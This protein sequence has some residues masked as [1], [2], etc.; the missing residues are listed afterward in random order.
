MKTKLDRFIGGFGSWE[1]AKVSYKI[2]ASSRRKVTLKPDRAP[3]SIKFMPALRSVILSGRNC[4]NRR[5][6]TSD[7]YSIW[8]LRESCRAS[9]VNY[10]QTFRLTKIH[11]N[12]NDV[13]CSDNWFVIS[14]DGRENEN[15]ASL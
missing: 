12:V 11:G 13:S 5:V 3:S 4:R 8:L 1:P 10:E 9:G 14:V 6:A 7:Y 15:S 2:L